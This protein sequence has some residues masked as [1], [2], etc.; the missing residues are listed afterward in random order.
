V[1]KAFFMLKIGDNCYK[2]KHWSFYK[3]LP[4]D[5]LGLDVANFIFLFFKM[6][7]HIPKNNKI[8]MFS[9]IFKTIFQ[10]TKCLTKK[11]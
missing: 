9:F 3:W 10:A 4:K 6:T 11:H 5:W 2:K 7:K 8:F 1:A